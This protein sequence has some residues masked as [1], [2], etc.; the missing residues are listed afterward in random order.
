[1]EDREEQDF[2]AAVLGSVPEF[3]DYYV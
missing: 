1:M 3:P 2:I